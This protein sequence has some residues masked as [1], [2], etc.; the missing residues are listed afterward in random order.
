MHL[1]VNT[2][3]LPGAAHICRSDRIRTR[4]STPQPTPSS[5]RNC[6][7]LIPGLSNSKTI[8]THVRSVTQART[9]SGAGRLTLVQ[10]LRMGMRNGCMKN[11]VDLRKCANH[12]WSRRRI[13]C[14]QKGINMDPRTAQPVLPLLILVGRCR[15]SVRSLTPLHARRPVELY[16]N[17]L[18]GSRPTQTLIHPRRVVGIT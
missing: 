8:P 4:L 2:P 11:L 15:R 13:A 1:M 10:R 18:P 9:Q 5:C 16:R 6:H 14:R 7:D 17:G 12:G 3:N